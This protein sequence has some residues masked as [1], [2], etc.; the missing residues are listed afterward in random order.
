MSDI[1]P[2]SVLKS[3]WTEDDVRYLRKYVRYLLGHRS[4]VP[5]VGEGRQLPLE[6]RRELETLAQSFV[7]TRG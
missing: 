4:A 2:G 6:R 5:T 3:D 1:T 7:D